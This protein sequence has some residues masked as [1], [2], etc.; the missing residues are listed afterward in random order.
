M[1][2]IRKSKKI[3]LLTL[4]VSTIFIT[5]GCTINF[6][7]TKNVKNVQHGDING[8]GEVNGKDVTKLMN[9]LKNKNANSLTAVGV[10]NADVNDDWS[11]DDKDTEIL[12]KYLADYGFTL[13]YTE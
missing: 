5:S 1:M 11:I 8:D 10:A 2:K 13:P 9:Y 3:I 7:A 12:M 6:S 4:L